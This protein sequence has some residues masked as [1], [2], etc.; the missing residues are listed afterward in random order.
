MWGILSFA[1]CGL[2]GIFRLVPFRFAELSTRY[3]NPG[4][5]DALSVVCIRL[6]SENLSNLLITYVLCLL[7]GN[8]SSAQ[9]S[10]ILLTH[11]IHRLVIDALIGGWDG[12]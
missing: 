3:S 10:F 2:R 7:V 4:H 8:V 11:Y 12:G 9:A 5:V 1:D 6:S